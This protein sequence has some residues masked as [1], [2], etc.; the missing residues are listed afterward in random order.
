MMR[1]QN[2]TNQTQVIGSKRNEN[3]AF[4]H[5]ACSMSLAEPNKT[6][7]EFQVLSQWV[8]D[9]FEMDSQGL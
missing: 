1:T 7:D 8:G 6:D 4:T 3:P 5:I 9:V 2:E